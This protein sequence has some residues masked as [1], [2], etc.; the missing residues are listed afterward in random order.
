M[1]KTRWPLWIASLALALGT[2]VPAAAQDRVDLIVLLD[3]SQSMIPYYNE[4]V[5]YVVSGTLREYMRFG[6]AFHLISFA[7][8]TQIELAQVLKTE[9]DVKAVLARLWLLYP[10]G[11]NTDL[12]GALRNAYQYVSDLPES[13]RKYIILITDGMHS[14]SAGSGNA[15]MTPAEVKAELESTAGKIRE[16]GWVMRIVRV[17]FDGS[18]GG[19]S[20]ELAGE[21]PGAGNYLDSVASALGVGMTDFDP[22][23]GTAALGR[24]I[25]LPRIEFD[26]DI[27]RR[28]YAFSLPFRLSNQS[29]E[30]LSVEL[31]AIL[32]PDG[33]DIL[34]KKL[35]ATLAPNATAS[36]GVK[37]LLPDDLAAGIQTLS[38]EPRFADGLRVNPARSDIRIDLRKAPVAAFFR[39]TVK[40]GLFLALLA[41]AL[42]ALFM[43]VRYVRS[44]HRRSERPIVD[45]VIDSQ[46]AAQAAS[47]A[48][49]PDS[50][51]A[52]ALLGASA[53]PRR[54]AGALLAESRA[55]T[56][57]D[58]AALLAGAG[59]KAEAR[60][61][62]RSQPGKPDSRDA[63]AL[64]ASR[65]RDSQARDPRVLLGTNAGS[66]DAAAAKADGA[67]SASLLA[68]W[69]SA[70][71]RT[72]GAGN[73][74][75]IRPGVAASAAR[76]RHGSDFRPALKKPGAAR[77]ELIVADQNTN[78]GSRNV[79][80]IHAGGRRSVGGR[81]SDFL[82]FLLP[83]PAR[84][85]DLHYDGE[86]LT[87][88][89][90]IDGFFPDYD[91]P[92]LDCLG[93]DIRLVTARG[94]ELTLRFERYVPPLDT[95]NKLLHCIDSPGIQSL[96][97]PDESAGEHTD[98]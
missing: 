41:L 91:G 18:D 15:S 57:R 85:A 55:G 67:K 56:S 61:D 34:R 66:G 69:T 35:L 75:A 74:A 51:N 50:R 3:S 98:R 84:V 38:V 26:A 8:S 2:A 23:N 43:A 17:P 16:R 12:V 11:K 90:A 22:E 20:G 81:S 94:R 29:A 42:L 47:N 45:A 6:D 39:N 73:V 87:L 13:G 48:Y 44:V 1:M 5:D 54:D 60:Q 28:D 76:R 25:A 96:A 32:L 88:V 14:P 9:E 86:N 80:T 21:S 33:R 68:A 40:A 64:L 58:A 77:F 10:L 19:A 89:P 93:Q 95:I 97:G 62:L 46:S 65:A 27:G 71:S 4:V 36:F 49:K 70:R 30:T 63:R 82:I 78:I 7:D 83:V 79:K 37:V 31:D 52:A 92:V 53:Q 72:S 59:A 24:T